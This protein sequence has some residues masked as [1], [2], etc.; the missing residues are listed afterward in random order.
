M[1]GGAGLASPAR[2]ASGGAD[3]KLLRTSP[4][5]PKTARSSPQKN[6]RYSVGRFSSWSVGAGGVQP[7]TPAGRAGRRALRSDRSGEIGEL[8]RGISLD[9]DVP[10]VQGVKINLDDICMGVVDPHD[11]ELMGGD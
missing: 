5:A 7:L 8:L 1:D 2:N 10:V 3:A 11:T 6:L 4:G 9:Q